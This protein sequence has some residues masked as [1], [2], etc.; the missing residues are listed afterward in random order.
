MSATATAP[1]TTTTTT[2]A[3]APPTTTTTTTTPPP[4]P[5]TPAKVRA[6][7]QAGVPL[8]SAKRNI[9]KQL[10]VVKNEAH[11]LSPEHK[12]LLIDAFSGL[13]IL[14]S[15]ELTALT[16]PTTPPAP[17]SPWGKVIA[18]GRGSRGLAVLHAALKP[19][20]GNGADE[21]ESASEKAG[22]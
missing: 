18:L 9:Q 17:D 12:Q 1:A 3:T 16:D 13:H 5:A 21:V 8:D 22:F 7:K 2:T 15:Q 11:G 20:E 19:G 10:E 14:I 4:A 6:A